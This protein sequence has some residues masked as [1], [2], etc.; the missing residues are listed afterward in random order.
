[1]QTELSSGV[2][3]MGARSYVPQ[4]GRFLQTDPIPGGSANAYVFGDP[5]N[6]SD[7]SGESGLPQWFLEFAAENA[8]QRA[9]EYAVR[10]KVA[11]EEATRRAEEAWAAASNAADA[12]PGGP[13]GPLGGSAGWACE[14]A[15]DTGQEDEACL[16]T[17][18]LGPGVSKDG[19]EAT[20]DSFGSIFSEALNSGVLHTI[21]Q[22]ENFASEIAHK[23]L[24][25]KTVDVTAQ[26][27]KGIAGA[28]FTAKLVDFVDFTP[29]GAAASYAIGVF[30]G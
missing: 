11:Q 20:A 14:D 9:E 1:L 6:E 26:C 2:I 22:A 17:I 10:E 18:S 21:K 8:Q 19:D 23:L 29:E 28:V 13:E 30:S 5:V 7:P 4:L 27:A 16:G 25:H 12:E 15:L 3:A 24:P